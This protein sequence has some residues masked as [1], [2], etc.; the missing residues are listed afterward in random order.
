MMLHLIKK[1]MSTN[2]ETTLSASQIDIENTSFE[3]EDDMN[4]AIK[5]QKS[6]K[7]L[8]PS[9]PDLVFDLDRNNQ[10][11]AN[12]TQVKKETDGGQLT[13]IDTYIQDFRIAFDNADVRGVGELN[14]DE[15]KNSDLKR[16][17]HDGK[18]SNDE[19]YKY[20]LKVD[21]NSRNSISWDELV[22]FIMRE[23]SV[24][25]VSSSVDQ[26]EFIHKFPNADVP[27]SCLHKELVVQIDYTARH[28]EYIS[29][30]CDSIR[31]WRAKDLQYSRCI[32]DPGDFSYML[33]VSRKNVLI[34]ATISRRIILYELDGLRKL[35][36]SVAASPLPI[37]IKMMNFDQAVDKLETM[38][39]SWIPLFNI[40]KCICETDKTQLS[41]FESFFFVG[42]DQGYVEAFLFQSPNIR[43]GTDFAISKLS[44]FRMHQAGVTKI[45]YLESNLCYASSSLDKTVKLWRYDSLNSK[46]LQLQCFSDKQ[47]IL[48]FHFSQAQKVLITYGASRDAYVWSLV[49]LKRTFRLGGHYSQIQN[50]IEYV[51]TN[52]ARY[53]ITVTIQNQFR[54]WDSVNYRLVREYTDR[55]KLTP[56]SHYGAAFFDDRRYAMICGAS[57]L[58]KWAEDNSGAFD[59]LENTTHSK[60]IIGCHYSQPFE[61][62][63][64]VDLSGDFIVWDINSGT[65]A[66]IHQEVIGSS[67]AVSSASTLDLSRK[68]LFTVN[69]K[70]EASLWNFSSASLMHKF[71]SIG[72]SGITSI[73]YFGKVRDKNFVFTTGQDKKINVYSE[74]TP[75]SYKLYR[76]SSY[77]VDVTAISLYPTCLIAGFADGS[78]A[79]ISVDTS[80]I[81]SKA[82][83][84]ENASVECMA[85]DEKAYLYV[86]D[87][88]G[89]LSVFSLPKLVRICSINAH[90]LV[91]TSSLTTISICGN[92]LFTGDAYGYCKVWHIKDKDDFGLE[93]VGFQRVSRDDV[94]TIDC[95][96]D[97][98]YLVTSSSD[99]RVRLWCLNNFEYVG[100]FSDESK[101]DIGNKDTWIIESPCPIE[102]AHFNPANVPFTSSFKNL[103]QPPLD[104]SS[105]EISQERRR[106]STPMSGTSSQRYEGGEE[107]S[108]FEIGQQ[109]ED[110]IRDHD[111]Y[112]TIKPPPAESPKAFKKLEDPKPLQ[113]S[114][115]H[116]DLLM[117]V[118]QLIRPNM[119]NSAGKE[120]KRP[121]LRIVP[122]R[123]TLKPKSK[124]STKPLLAFKM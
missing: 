34:V 67:H 23:A 101:W 95:V 54:F 72:N 92:K 120:A 27:K 118:N 78:I 4:S 111:S 102:A 33:V 40:P 70:A 62:I 42:D 7:S 8:N 1:Q 109:I 89:F 81:I 41:P 49:T 57:K 31:F 84:G 36:T 38:Q 105:P 21:V 107:L 6:I 77:N 80:K 94:V 2:D 98:N 19:F 113:T 117:K 60:S 71:S 26:A 112:V 9:L 30:S 3:D 50:I 11:N 91:V 86:G 96:K 64:T 14:F 75:D 12:D 122:A 82:M 103:P 35:P 43:Q 73:I 79:T 53:I 121:I 39:S 10:K 44:K 28:D 47:P 66:I 69:I 17:I 59:K 56:F 110:Y 88:R 5:T 25:T 83:I 63:I 61:Q 124:A 46:F 13:N 106:P 55:E 123:D 87:S 16:Y 104:S 68:R 32:C 74:V 115:R 97:S 51:T 29:L 45:C 65:K 85:S 93:E 108:I 22:N 114:E 119:S 90:E 15:W 24:T 99:Q 58:F 116:V 20:F 52:G 37:E 48:G 76:S 100:L 18:L